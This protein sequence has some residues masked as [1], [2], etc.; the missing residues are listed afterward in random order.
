LLVKRVV[1]DFVTEQNS[2]G[3]SPIDLVA[4]LHRSGVGATATEPLAVAE[5]RVN[6]ERSNRT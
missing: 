4:Q 1:V 2:D 6:A 3:T 5:I